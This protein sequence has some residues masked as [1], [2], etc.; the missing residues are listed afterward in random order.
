MAS[1]KIA[2]SLLA[3]LRDLR[4]ERDR[5][6]SAIDNL[7]GLLEQGV[8]TT[9]KV[10]KPQS[11]RSKGWDAAA[12]RA[13]AERMRRYWA[14]RKGAKK[15]KKKATKARKKTTKKAV[16]SRSWTPAKRAAAA[17]RMRKYWADRRKSQHG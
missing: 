1:D 17:E 3:A 9:R 8:A 16:R 14:E 10:S 2:Q 7:E 6:D 15:G 4:Q 5:I 11:R 13:A 12:R